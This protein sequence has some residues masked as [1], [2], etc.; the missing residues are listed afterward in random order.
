MKKTTS[1]IL[2]ALLSLLLFAALISCGGPGAATTETAET[3]TETGTAESGDPSPAESLPGEQTG[4]TDGAQPT[5]PPTPSA[6]QST[7]EPP[8]STN[9]PTEPVEPPTPTTPTPAPTLTPYVDPDFEKEAIGGVLTVEKTADD[10]HVGTLLLINA[11][12][13]YDPASATVVNGYNTV[14]SRPTTTGYIGFQTINTELRSDLLEALIRMQ[15][16]LV[17][18]T[19]TK[20]KLVV[21]ACYLTAEKLE[22]K[23]SDAR[24]G[25]YQDDDPNGS[26]HGAG[27]GVNLTFNDTYTYRL[28]ESAVLKET[29]W[30]YEN[31][32]RFG[33]IQRYTE[34][35]KGMTGH[36]AELG[37]FRYVGIPHATYIYRH[38]ITLDEY[39]ELIK[40]YSFESPMVITDP[41]GYDW[42]VYYVQAED[43]STT[44]EMPIGLISEISGNNKDGFII[45]VKGT[46]TEALSPSEP[47]IL[48][49]TETP[50]SD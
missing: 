23:E 17:I 4:Q 29:N 2:S 21:G 36:A 5:V 48:P 3:A 9:E 35:G 50:L 32:H 1:R 44:V 26:E 45:S 24:F 14:H 7:T 39:I 25:F 12:Y 28:G 31:A 20:K 30:I 37:H 43:G 13:G 8:V 15:H 22:D 16:A 40:S 49:I 41:Y 18:E 33:F 46:Y 47:T 38:G 27:I 10:V 42:S 19:G 34:S 6:G 11:S